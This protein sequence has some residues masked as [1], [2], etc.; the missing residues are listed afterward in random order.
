MSSTPSP[1]LILDAST[2]ALK[3]CDGGSSALRLALRLEW[4]N[5]ATPGQWLN[6][7]V[8]RWTAVPG[9]WSGRAESWRIELAAAPAHQGLTVRV[10]IRFDGV[11]LAPPLRGAALGVHGF[12]ARANGHVT[13]ALRVAYCGAHSRSR[14]SRSEARPLQGDERERGWW[15]GALSAPRGPSLVLGA[16]SVRRFVTEM[17]LTTDHLAGYQHL[18]HWILANGEALAL[19][20]FWIGT[21][22]VPPLDR[23]E[24]FA[25]RLALS[26]GAA[27]GPSPCGW[28]SWGHWL[29][30]I[31]LGLMREM[32][33]AL[34]GIPSLRDAVRIVQIDDGWSELLESGRVSSSWRPNRRFPSGIAPLAAEIRRAERDC[35]LWLLPFT[36]N[37]GSTIVTQHPEWLVH[38]EAGA[39]FRVGGSESY[40]LDPTHPA[41]ADWLRELFARMRDWGVRYVKLD[42]LRV[43]LA[44]DP[45]LPQDG[46]DTKRRYHDARTR[47]E[48]YRAGLKL[49]RDVMG[50]DAI[51]VGC[52]APAAA[53]VGLVNTHRVGP[54]IEPRWVGHVA[55]VRD[56]ARALIANWFWQGRTWVNDPDYLLSCD[57]ESLTRFWATVVALSGGSTVL[58]A[59]LAELRSW[60]EHILSF[61]IPPISRAARPLD[62]FEHGPE[63]RLLHLPLHR[64]G[65]AWS[66]VGLLNWQDGPSEHELE[67]AHLG[68]QGPA[69]IWDAWRQSHRI[70]EGSCRIL[71]DAHDAV[72]LRVTPVAPRPQVVGTDVHWAQ[73]WLEF[74]AA[75][76]D[77]VN[78]TLSMRVPASAPRAGHAWIWAPDEWRPADG[79]ET[80]RGLLRGSLAP[81]ATLICRFARNS[82]NVTP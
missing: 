21:D 10:S 13:T 18:E 1:R 77:A 46:F 48:A 34:E 40:C 16:E 37:S 14:T 62:L 50:D 64:D 32:V 47:V 52:S 73:G 54:D 30:R 35:G 60:Q 41:A 27:P 53:G 12:A 74:D 67:L 2:G 17:T 42:H 44:P 25:D 8:A 56:A 39:P 24:R 68:I 38:D 20:P 72:L 7:T 19:E 78:A 82:N 23:L 66:M 6:A 76:W 69:H 51:L 58:S 45:E 15:V 75:R 28:G 31:D 61:A 4:W 9:S 63:P 3:L 49:V 70:V 11:G 55:G 5:P 43:L 22:D 79:C 33:L 29:E 71:I 81:G 36:V 57:S 80:M 65:E 26:H 59:D